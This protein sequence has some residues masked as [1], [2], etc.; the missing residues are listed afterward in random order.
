MGSKLR[1][2]LFAF[3]GQSVLS[4]RVVSN[5]IDHW[6]LNRKGPKENLRTT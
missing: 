1:G 5:D 3:A 6:A 2:L 4:K